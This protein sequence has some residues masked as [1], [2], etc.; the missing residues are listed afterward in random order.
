[1]STGKPYN[2]PRLNP[3]TQCPNNSTNRSRSTYPN[4]IKSGCDKRRKRTSKQPRHT[5]DKPFFNAPSVI[6]P[7][8]VKRHTTRTANR[9]LFTSRPH[10]ITRPNLT[11]PTPRIGHWTH[12]REA[13]LPSNLSQRQQ[14][15]RWNHETNRTRLQTS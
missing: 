2:T 5:A 3:C 8:T 6:Y 9:F 1:M 15:R 13:V 14:R 10:S 4:R 11:H 12:G 7:T